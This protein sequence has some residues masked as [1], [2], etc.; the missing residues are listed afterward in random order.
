MS[1]SRLK[2]ISPVFIILLLFGCAQEE[3]KPLMD[4]PVVAEEVVVEGDKPEPVKKGRSKLHYV[5]GRKLAETNLQHFSFFGEFFGGRA[6]FF[7]NHEQPVDIGN[8]RSESVM[9][10]FLDE[11]LSKIK[12]KMDEDIG[13]YLLNRLGKCKI[14][15]LDSLTTVRIRQGSFLY[16]SDSGLALS[17]D[18]KYYRLRWQKDDLEA[19]YIV[20]RN[21]IGEKPLYAYEEKISDFKETMLYLEHYRGLPQPTHGLEEF[22][23]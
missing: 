11:D 2:L 8:G 7:S 21:V 13:P 3:E 5:L 10:T 16:A 14:K 9:L 18:L 23:E 15:G 12:Y 17:D 22:M 20:K 19:V 6:K 4:E 1:I